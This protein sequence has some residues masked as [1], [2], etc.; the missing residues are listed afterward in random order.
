MATGRGARFDGEALRVAVTVV[1]A[2]RRPRAT[3]ER[4][5]TPAPALETPRQ[6]RP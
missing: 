4:E 6:R 1:R 5:N 2:H 3:R